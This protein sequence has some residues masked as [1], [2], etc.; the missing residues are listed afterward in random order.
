MSSNVCTFF[1]Q[2]ALKGRYYGKLKSCTLLNYERRQ[3]NPWRR[4]F[5]IF[6]FLRVVMI[7]KR[8]DRVT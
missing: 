6:R 2:T 1:A 4:F 8:S 5:A 3:V 7:K